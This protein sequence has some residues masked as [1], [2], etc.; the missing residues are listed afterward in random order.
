MVEKWV[1]ENER[2]WLN[3]QKWVNF[4]SCD[5]FLAKIPNFYPQFLPSVFWC[6]QGVW[7]GN[8]GQKWVKV[9][10]I[11]I[12]KAQIAFWICLLK[13]VSAILHN[14]KRTMC[15]LDILNEILSIGIQLIVVLSSHCFTNIY[16]LPSYHAQPA[17]V[18]LLA[19][20]K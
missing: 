13:L 3:F 7:N 12:S 10:G 14:F 11:A 19:L 8:I 9:S 18:K 6:F 4:L 17:F 2:K 5:P 1:P 20:K 16:S 15:C